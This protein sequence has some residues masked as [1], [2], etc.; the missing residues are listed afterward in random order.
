MM[1][2]AVTVEFFHWHL[3]LLNEEQAG[4]DLAEAC[5]REY[6]TRVQTLL[7]YLRAR[8]AGDFVAVWMQ[9]GPW[10]ACPDREGAS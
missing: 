1:A 9:P 10:S 3:A 6:P 7:F 4:D 5:L 8:D 2:P